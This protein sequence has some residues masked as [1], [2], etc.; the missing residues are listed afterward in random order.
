M[1]RCRAK[2]LSTRR[3]ITPGPVLLPGSVGVVSHLVSSG[4]PHSKT[5]NLCASD[6]PREL[7]K[8]V[9]IVKLW[10]VRRKQRI[11]IFCEQKLLLCLTQKHYKASLAVEYLQKQFAEW[12]HFKIM[13]ISPRKTKQQDYFEAV[14]NADIVLSG[15]QVCGKKQTFNESIENWKKKKC[16]F[17][18]PSNA[19]GKIQW[20]N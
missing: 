4:I 20:T 11:G 5:D 18:C 19:R 2:R 12:S 14:D 13:L 6:T 17:D 1:P 8:S 15:K 10:V 9:G 3:G 7:Q 16:L